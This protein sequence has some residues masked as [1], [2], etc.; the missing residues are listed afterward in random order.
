[1][2]NLSPGRHCIL[3]GQR[4][5][6]IFLTE[7]HVHVVLNQLHNLLLVDLAQLLNKGFLLKGLKTFSKEG[8]EHLFVSLVGR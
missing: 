6:V 2:K 3:Y 5:T 1:M 7:D 4:T 8:L